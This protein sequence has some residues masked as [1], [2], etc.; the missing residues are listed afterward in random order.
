M[1]I[2]T[3]YPQMRTQVAKRLIKFF[4]LL[5]FPFIWLCTDLILTS[6]IS[7]LSKNLTIILFFG[8]PIV[9]FLIGGYLIFKRNSYKELFLLLKKNFGEFIYRLVIVVFLI[10]L[11]VAICVVFIILIFSLGGSFSDAY[12][13][14][15]TI[16]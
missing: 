15:N 13:H 11:G 6:N 2:I 3:I 8:H 14:V 9:T 7:Q 10:N 5:L 4:L 1:E 12:D 16:K